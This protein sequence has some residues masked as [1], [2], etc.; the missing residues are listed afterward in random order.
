MKRERQYSSAS[1]RDRWREEAAAIEG[2]PQNHEERSQGVATVDRSLERER[3]R[4]SVRRAQEAL[5]PLLDALDDKRRHARRAWT[6]RLHLTIEQASGCDRGRI[7]ATVPTK[8]LSRSGFSFV[9]RQYIPEGSIITMRVDCV[10]DAPTLCGEVRR[11]AHMGG[12]DH[13][14]GVEFTKVSRS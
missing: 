13:L 12:M 1:N 8:D 4:D 11:C 10:P 6:T 2:A 7:D 14:I 5:G 9:Y 3:D